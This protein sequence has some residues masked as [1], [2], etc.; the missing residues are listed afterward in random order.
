MAIVKAEMKNSLDALPDTLEVPMIVGRDGEDVLL[1]RAQTTRKATATS[2][3]CG[4]EWGSARADLYESVDYEDRGGIVL[5]LRA[6]TDTGGNF[7]PHATEIEGGVE[8]CFAGDGEAEAFCR[9]LSRVLA[10]RS[11]RREVPPPSF[12]VG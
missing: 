2:S 10:E 9:L 5:R 8:I 1:T 4:S 6:S 12:P 11:E 7:L 3:F